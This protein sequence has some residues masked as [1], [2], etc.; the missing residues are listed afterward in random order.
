MLSK[1]GSN[2]HFSRQNLA[3][4]NLE[5][6]KIGHSRTSPITP[7]G[8]IGCKLNLSFLFDN[9]AH[10]RWASFGDSGSITAGFNPFINATQFKETLLTFPQ[11]SKLIST[12]N[13]M[14][15]VE[16]SKILNNEPSY[17]FLNASS[18]ILAPLIVSALSHS[19]CQQQWN[20]EFCLT[21]S[22][23]VKPRH[24]IKLSVPNTYKD[25]TLV[26]DLPK[27]IRSKISF[28]NPK[29]LASHAL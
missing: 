4:G 16:R 28:Y 25:L 27:E 8:S 20:L 15:S 29:K 14:D 9:Y 10:F 11:F 5:F 6:F 18:H 23:F 7:M 17:S 24:I 26:S 1:L 2:A 22:F 19:T 21:N 3:K 13:S 12:L